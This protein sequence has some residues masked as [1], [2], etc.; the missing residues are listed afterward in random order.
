MQTVN[1]D[2]HYLFHLCLLCSSDKPRAVDSL[3]ILS[4]SGLLVEYILEPHARTGLDKV[5]D[6]SPLEVMEIPRA[7]WILRR[8][9]LTTSWFLLSNLPATV[10]LNSRVC[11]LRIQTLD[12]FQQWFLAI[13]LLFSETLHIG[14]N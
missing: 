13:P 10:A 7:Q 14:N 8:Y 2:V 9:N 6:Q 3:Y 12:E 5:T 4:W 1:I 11:G